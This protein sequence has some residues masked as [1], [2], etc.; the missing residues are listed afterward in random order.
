MVQYT[1]VY[2]HFDRGVLANTPW[3]IFSPSFVK[4]PIIL[5]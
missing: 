1:T 3:C 2:V 5:G 4:P